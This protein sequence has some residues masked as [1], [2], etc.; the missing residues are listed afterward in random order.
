MGTFAERLKQAIEKAG[1][2][3]RQVSMAI[4]LSSAVIGRYTRGTATPNIDTAQKIATY[5]KVPL[6]WLITGNTED[7]NLNRMRLAIWVVTQTQI[8]LKLS[9]RTADSQADTIMAVYNMLA[10]SD[11][12]SG[13]DTSEALERMLPAVELLIKAAA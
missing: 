9:P 2:S 12:F 10:E 13:T 4:G 6:L 8:K 5:L 7:L 3:E 11:A 1:H